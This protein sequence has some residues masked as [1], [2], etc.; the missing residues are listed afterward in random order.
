MKY[1]F[2]S[3]SVTFDPSIRYTIWSILLGSTFSSIT[4]YACIQTQA[5][6]YMC[7]K[8]AKTAQKFVFSFFFFTTLFFLFIRVAWTNYIMNSVMLILFLFTGC[9]IYTKYNQCD[10]LRA[11]L[12]SRP[13]QV[14]YELLI[15]IE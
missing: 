4:Q 12:I 11:K 10:P 2:Y 8:D 1:L 14:K 13:D 5:Q 3:I 7:V 6:R 9:L 15:Q